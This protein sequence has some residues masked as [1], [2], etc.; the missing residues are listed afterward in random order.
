VVV[1]G[2][3]Q[4]VDVGFAHDHVVAQL[5]EDLVRA[6]A[7]GEVVAAE[8][9]RLTLSRWI[10]GNDTFF[11]DASG[12]P[13]EWRVLGLSADGLALTL[14]GAA[15]NTT[16]A[17][18]LLT[19]F[20]AG[21]PFPVD[22]DFT[23]GDV[24]VAP[25]VFQPGIIL[26]AAVD[27]RT[28]GSFCLGAECRPAGADLIFGGA[29]IA[30]ARNDIGAA[31]VTTFYPAD[32]IVTLPTGHARDADAIAGDNAQ[33]F[34]LVGI[35]GVDSGAFLTFNYDDPAYNPGG[36]RLIPRAVEF[37]DY[38][39]GGPAYD[40]ASAATDRG[41]ADE[42]HG[43]AGDDWIYGMVGNDVLFGDGQDDDIIGGYGDEWISG[44]T[45][46]D[47]IIGDDGRISTSR[48]SSVYGEPL[49]GIA[50]LR[51]KDTDTRTANGDVLNE[52]IY[53]PG[54][55][56]TETINVG[57]VLKKT[58]NLTPFNVDPTGLDPLFRPAGGYDD[59]V[60]GGLGNDAIHGGSG[61]DALSG[62]EALVEGWARDYS[63]DG[64][65]VGILRIDFGH[66]V[67]PGDVLRYNPEDPDGWHYDRTQR[68]GEFDLYDEYEPR[69]EI[70][71]NASG[72][73]WTCTGYSPSGHTCTES[74]PITSYLFTYFLT[75]TSDE[76]YEFSGCTAFLPNGTCVGTGIQRTDGNDVLFGDLGND[77]IVGG[78][79]HD[80][81]WGGWGNDLLQAD[82]V[83]TTNG[84]LNDVPETHP[85]FEDRAY[86]GAG[87]DVL[88]GNTGGDRL[89][90]WIGEFN[91]YIVPFAPFG[92]A[93]VSRQRPPALDQFLYVL[94]AAQGADPTRVL[95]EGSLDPARNGEPH[96]E[97]GLITPRDG[98]I[99][100]DQSGAPADP[101]AGNIPGGTRDILRSA[102]F[103][104]GTLT[105]FA[106]D[107]GVWL[108]VDGVLTV[109]AGSLGQDAASVFYL[110][111]ELPTYYEIQSSVSVQKAL[112]GWKSNAYVMFDYQSAADFKFAG[113]DAS[114][115]KVVIGH[116]TATGWVYD[117]QVPLLVKENRYY[118]ILVVVNGLLVTG[119]VDGV[120]R[121]SFQFA[122]AVVDGVASGLNT[123]LVGVGSDNSRGTFDN[124]A[125]LALPPQE[126]FEATES[127]D[128]ADPTLSFTGEGWSVDGGVYVGTAPAGGSSTSLLANLP[129]RATGDTYLEIS[130]T[131]SPDAGAAGGFTFDHY[132]ADDFKFV[133]LTDGIVT[134]GHMIRGRW[135][136][137]ATFP[138]LLTGALQLTLEGSTVEVSVG[139]TPIGSFSYNASI[140]DGDL[141]LLTSGGTTAYDDVRVFVGTHFINVIDAQ[142]PMLAVPKDIT[143]NTD[144]G[145]STAFV[146]DATIG[147][148][149][150][151]DNVPGVVVTREGVPASNLFPIGVTVITW[152]ATDVF[153]NTTIGTQT[154]TIVDAEKPVLAVPPDVSRELPAGQTSITLTAAELGT[155]TASDNSGSVTVT[156]SGIPDGLVFPLGTTTITWTATDPSGN[157]TT[158]LQT[159][160]ITTPLPAITVVATD[161]SGSEAGSDPITFTVSRSMGDGLLTV[162]L[163]WSGE[164]VYGVDYSVTAAGGT[165]SS[166]GTSLTFG[167]G[168]AS[169]TL[170]VLPIDDVVPESAESVLL[171]VVAGSGYVVGAPASAVAEI[172]A[173]DDAPVTSTV[174]VTVTYGT[175]SE[176]GDV[177]AFTVGRVGDTSAQVVITLAWSGTATFG[178]DYTVS[179][180]GLSADGKSLTLL[181]GVS[182]A[183]VT[184][185]PVDD[186]LVEPTEG[187]V[188]AVLAGTG[189]V[190]G[191]QTT[192]TG[193]IA[194]N[195][196]APALPTVSI[197][198][199]DQTGAETRTGEPVDTV[200]FTLTRTGDT[201]KALVVGFGWFGSAKLG[202]DF[203]AAV[204]GSGS[205][206]KTTV[207]FAAGQGTLTL[208]IRPLDDLTVEAL[209]AVIITLKAGTGY[210][211]GAA[212]S[213]TGTIADNDGAAASATTF[214]SAN[215]PSSQDTTA[216]TTTL[217]ATTDATPVAIDPVVALNAVDAGTLSLDTTSAESP[218]PATD[219]EP[220]PAA[221]P[222]G[223]KD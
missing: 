23:V 131:V 8:V 16:A 118:D 116:R 179:G 58:V 219:A 90:D 122:P 105:G 66:P 22:V 129:P 143:R 99:W 170:T 199:T 153:G 169:V 45:G 27:W 68:A 83:L 128:G 174:G 15:V 136:A 41:A 91:S 138:T 110:D 177:L 34:R 210:T 221:R 30:I 40:A 29:G 101:Q 189:Y 80:T 125:V 74:A 152:T 39:L 158:E 25:R 64:N 212:S 67:N 135:I 201:S 111:Q 103:N 78:T 222:A 157:A 11:V 216:A 89:I 121:V 206:S 187:V 82:D 53:T 87:R 165:L 208:L 185:T 204:V 42:I 44:G 13:V 112:A 108:V 73:V 209:E 220:A 10:S 218:A 14:V 171:A 173:D 19:V 202:K 71:F 183:V 50:A 150:A 31:T 84:S 117:I 132:A 20:G 102:N 21:L 92:I 51:A 6:R 141:G 215:A 124:F 3:H 126:T 154:V 65:L 134:I 62:A 47:G 95:D 88:I 148:A 163:R 197:A 69:R 166:T 104:D 127:F 46:D 115:N 48:N 200:T 9:E 94:S 196:V 1:L 109:A 193:T 142:A 155:A 5:A 198:A 217:T 49:Y 164:A 145:Q 161:A 52:F 106:P 133:T 120:A 190:L 2:Q 32:T 4:A 60:F 123:G 7:T 18:D 61:D 33:I 211:L 186:T 195:D 37:L 35:N 24:E 182:S 107:S 63:G 168:V 76:G 56:Q 77:W 188:L 113:I 96:G 162:A 144:P 70:R 55:I 159:V 223:R 194:D 36:L 17:G 97:I 85:M 100:R 176:S 79:G 119:W 203:T 140:L 184:V 175:G 146:S 137:D 192:A 178:T 38:T 59:I 214:T 207:T 98:A 43:E 139:G 54:Q 205:L 114:T 160:T 151:T 172:V 72:E 191:S 12:R 167:A 180:T 213:A 57:G 181:A 147:T 81:L 26:T 149:I 86:G 156:S 28:L 93:T 130:G 75:N